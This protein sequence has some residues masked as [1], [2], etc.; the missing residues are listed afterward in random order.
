MRAHCQ[1]VGQL[2]P[3]HLTKLASDADRA[4]RAPRTVGLPNVV[5]VAG[6][7]GQLTWRLLA[8]DWRFAAVGATPTNQ[9]RTHR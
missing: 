3:K 1:T 8:S 9:S 2:L 4:R 5:S 7:A 6:E